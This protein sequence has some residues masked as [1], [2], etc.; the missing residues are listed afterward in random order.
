MTNDFIQ[1]LKKNTSPYSIEKNL[2]KYIIHK[3]EKKEKY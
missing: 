2:K 3:I 1:K